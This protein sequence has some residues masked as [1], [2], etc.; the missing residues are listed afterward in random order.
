[1]PPAASEGELCCFLAELGNELRSTSDV[2]KLLR[3]ALRAFEQQMR[4]YLTEEAVIIGV[5]TRSSYPI[6]VLRAPHTLASPAL[7]GLYPCA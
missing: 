4:G 5:N 3:T 6:R 1:M 2:D 7:D